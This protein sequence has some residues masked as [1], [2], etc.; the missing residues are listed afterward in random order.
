MSS[1]PPTFVR[2]GEKDM[3]QALADA[4]AQEASGDPDGALRVYLELVQRDDRAHE[5]KYRAGTAL[6]RRGD[7]DEA[8]TLL[9]QVSFACPDHVPA[10]ANLGNALLLLERIEPARDAFLA[11]LE[12]APDNRN[13]LYGLATVLMRLGRP[14][15]AAPFALRL[16]ELLPGSAAVLTLD[17]DAQAALN[18]VAPAIAQYRQAL[19]IDPAYGPALTG[20]AETL[21]RQNRLDDAEDYARKAAHIQP[22]SASL[23]ALLG[24]ILLARDDLSGALAAFDAAQTRE[25]ENP[26]HAVQ[27]SSCYRRAGD[28]IGALRQAR[29]AWEL[30]PTG[31]AAANALGTAL[32]AAGAAQRA[33][34]VLMCQGQRDK[35]PDGFWEEVEALIVHLDTQARTAAAKRD[36]QERAAEPAADLDGAHGVAALPDADPDE[37]EATDANANE[38]G[39][40]TDR[41]KS[42]APDADEPETLPLFPD[43]P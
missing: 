1:Q 42:P 14:D 4:A 25:P 31:K 15:E 22:E 37:R 21:F 36:A 18:R 11:V 26:D 2:P 35:V 7:L 29:Y 19:R 5:A 38:A 3:D 28:L 20:L 13:A 40:T 39:A 16:K 43:D 32:A 33:R 9:R 17:A 34:T 8:V 10:R 41:R 24:R 6:M 23:Q 30:D 27:L 12:R